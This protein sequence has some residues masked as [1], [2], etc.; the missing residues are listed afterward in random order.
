MVCE[1]LSSIMNLPCLAGLFLA[2][3]NA[4][5]A[6]DL[7][8]PIIINEINAET[9]RGHNAQEFIELRFTGTEFY[10]CLFP[11]ALNLKACD[12]KLQIPVY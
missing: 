11:K 3:L 2:V 6:V 8:A 5:T 10:L 9:P 12:Q 4:Y 7:M 1:I